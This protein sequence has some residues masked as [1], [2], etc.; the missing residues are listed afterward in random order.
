MS[1]DDVAMIRDKDGSLTAA[2]PPRPHTCRRGWRGTDAEG[3]PVPCLVCRPH[4]ARPTRTPAER[5]TTR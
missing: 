4:L 1:A 5:A 2:P 3:R